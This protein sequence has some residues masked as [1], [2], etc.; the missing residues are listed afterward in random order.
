MIYLKPHEACADDVYKVIY[1]MNAG[2]MT[3]NSLSVQNS[4]VSLSITLSDFELASLL[5]IVANR[6]RG[7]E[8]ACSR[9]IFKWME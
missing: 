3:A 1:N 2:K 5:N 4:E 8:K 7:E 9:P 6:L